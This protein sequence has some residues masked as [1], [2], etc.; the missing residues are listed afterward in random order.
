[1][2]C[3]CIQSVLITEFGEEIFLFRHDQHIV[4]SDEARQEED[5]R[6]GQVC[7]QGDASQE[8]SRAEVDG[9]P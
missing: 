6:P 9:I 2:N 3:G 4:A 7:S 5:Q 1:M 8:T